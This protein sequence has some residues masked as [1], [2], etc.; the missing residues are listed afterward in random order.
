LLANAFRQL[1]VAYMTH[2][3]RQQAGSYSLGSQEFSEI[4]RERELWDLL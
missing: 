4:E 3:I 2:R 1:P